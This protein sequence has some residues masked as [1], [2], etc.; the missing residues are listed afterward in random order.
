[1]RTRD[2]PL[3]E[4]RLHSLQQETFNYFW[5]EGNPENGLLSDNTLK[6]GDPASI[7]GVGMALSTYVSAEQPYKYFLK[8]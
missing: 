7:A 2:K 5:K 6:A 4:E 1:M 8:N 3:Q